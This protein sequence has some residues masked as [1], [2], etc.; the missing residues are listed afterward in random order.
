MTSTSM[1][2]KLIVEGIL[3]FLRFNFSKETPKCHPFKPTLSMSLT[4]FFISCFLYT[5]KKCISLLLRLEHTPPLVEGYDHE[6]LGCYE[7][8][9]DPI[10]AISK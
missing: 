1:K 9:V 3:I 10:R 4:H 2:I 8:N 5:T 6:D 7:F